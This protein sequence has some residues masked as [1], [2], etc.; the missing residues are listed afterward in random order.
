MQHAVHST[1]PSKAAIDK[2]DQLCAIGHMASRDRERRG[3]CAADGDF[4]R[5]AFRKQAAG[6]WRRTGHG[7]VPTG[8]S[9]WGA[10]AWRVRGAPEQAS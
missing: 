1:A 8:S 7:A 6:D 2:R 3:N 4:F 10:G 9:S 5:E